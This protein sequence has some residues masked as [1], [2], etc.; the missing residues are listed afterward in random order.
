MKEPHADTIGLITVF[1]AILRVG[2]AVRNRQCLYGNRMAITFF[3]IAQLMNRNWTKL[4][5]RLYSPD[6]KDVPGLDGV[7]LIFNFPYICL[8]FFPRTASTQPNVQININDRKIKKWRVKSCVLRKLFV[9][10]DISEHIFA[11][12]RGYCLYK[13]NF[14]TNQNVR[15]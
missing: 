11:P 3:N 12:N 15:F 4:G 9:S 13:P 5:R 2:K 7:Q 14:L 8:Y 6:L 10:G 1:D